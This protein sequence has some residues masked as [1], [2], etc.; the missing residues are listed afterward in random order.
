MKRWLDERSHMNCFGHYDAQKAT[1]QTP[2]KARRAPTPAAAVPTRRSRSGRCGPQPH[3]SPL[4]A[5]VGDP[6]RGERVH[7]TDT[8]HLLPRAVWQRSVRRTPVPWQFAFISAAIQRPSYCA[9][10]WG[11]GRN[12]CPG[13]EGISA[14]MKWNTSGGSMAGH[15][16]PLPARAGGCTPARGVATAKQPSRFRPTRALTEPLRRQISMHPYIPTP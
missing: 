12:Y 3:Q 7:Q 14:G 2:N 10:G 1:K 13:K 15:L 9:R 8:A 4:S 11:I 6:Q 5:L 16:L